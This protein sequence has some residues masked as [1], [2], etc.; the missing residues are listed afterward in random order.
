[1]DIG[2]F[3]KRERVCVC[4]EFIVRNRVNW[5]PIV[6][7]TIIYTIGVHNPIVESEVEIGLWRVHNSDYL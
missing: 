6:D 5:N 7:S 3:F 1:M 2:I 4:V